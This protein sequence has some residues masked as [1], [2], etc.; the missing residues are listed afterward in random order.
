MERMHWLR[1]PSLGAG[2][3]VAVLSVAVITGLNYA[4]REVAPAVSTGFVYL[5]AVLL[6]SS[7]WGLWLGVLT[8]VLGAAAFNFFH[9]PPTGTFTVADAENWVALT[10]FVAAA[11]VISTLADRVRLRA[12]EAQQRRLEADLAAGMARLLLGGASVA[13]SMPAVGNVI[14]RTLG[15]S[16]VEVHTGWVDADARRH[17]IPLLV[18]GERAGTVLVRRG[19]DER[20]LD[21]IRERIVPALETLVGAARRRDQLESQVIETK[22][23]RRSDVIKTALLRSA[24]HDLRSP[25]AAITAAAGGLDSDTLSD[26]ARRELISVIQTEGNRLARLV[27]DLLDLSRLEAGSASPRTDWCSLEEVVTASLEAAPEP[28]GGFDVDLDDD[29]PLVK[30]DPAQLERALANVLENATRYAGDAP[31]TVRGRTAG[32]GVVLRVHDSGPGIPKHELERVFE[33]FHQ[34]DDVDGAGSGLGLAIARG[35]TE[36]N[37][38]RLRAESLPAR[39]RRSC[40]ASRC[41]R[42]RAGARAGLRRR[43]PDPARAPGDSP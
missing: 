16:T 43:A 35:F 1:R 31:V 28:P 27:E 25:L 4:L 24:S 32:T 29:L 38:G 23:L 40:S 34:G 26:E 22:A 14:G 30:A 11:V 19:E 33:P 20:A 3:T 9:L 7:R 5:L 10:M 17:A 8:G 6:V 36:A 42:E 12:E 15:L 39:G 18:A 37:G 21:T 41:R 13:E 2:L